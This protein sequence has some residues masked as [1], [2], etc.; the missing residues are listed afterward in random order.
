PLGFGFTL[1]GLGGL[2][3]I[4]R[5]LDQ[6]ALIGLV[7][8][9]AVDGLLFPAAGD[10]LALAPRGERLLPET[11]D[12]FVFPP[13]AT[14]GWGRPGA[15]LLAARVALVV[16]LRTGGGAPSIASIAALGQADVVLPNRDEAIVELHVA[17]A[18]SVELENETFLLVAS[19]ERSRIAMFHVS[20]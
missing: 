10:A 2:A 12:R 4:H 15:S 8:A 19:L 16:D 18:A 5:A 11:R 17:F 20:G 7:Q 9:G 13:I 3:G 14:I 1:N 6:S